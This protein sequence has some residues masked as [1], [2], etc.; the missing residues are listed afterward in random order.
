MSKQLTTT[1]ER[2]LKAAEKCV[3]AKSALEI[4]FPEAFKGSVGEKKRVDI[5]ELKLGY[6]FTGRIAIKYRNEPIAFITGVTPFET[7][8]NI[9]IFNFGERGFLQSIYMREHK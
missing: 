2:V 9:Y 3:D 4:L 7:L 6:S 1:K 8:D 5:K